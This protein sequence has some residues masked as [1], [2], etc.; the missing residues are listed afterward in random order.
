M[1]RK[2]YYDGKEL[3]DPDPAMSIDE[4]RQSMSDF[5]PELSNATHTSKK[6]GDDEVITFAKRVGTKG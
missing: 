2:F 5:F 3:P 4:V 1:A 6:D